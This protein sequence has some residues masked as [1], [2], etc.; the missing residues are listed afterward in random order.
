[1]EVTD[2]QLD[3]IN[4]CFCN[5]ECSSDQELVDFLVEEG[6]SA[7]V[8]ESAALHLPAIRTNPLAQLAIKE[9]QFVVIDVRSLMIG[10]LAS[11][12]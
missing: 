7:A 10:S 5:D 11:A 8:A 3:I 4:S 9:G 2:N 6:I 12:V 1:M